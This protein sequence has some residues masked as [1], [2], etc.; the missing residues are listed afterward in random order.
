[1]GAGSGYTFF[2]NEG[3]PVGGATQLPDRA[4]Q[5]GAP[6]HWMSNVQV[7]DVDAT[8][9]EAKKLNGRVL[10]EPSEYSGVGRYALIADPFGAVI[11]VLVPTQPMKVRDVSR[12]G[13]VCWHE[14]LSEDHEASLAFYGKLFGWKKRSEFDMG[15]MGKYVLYGDDARDLGGMFTKPKEMH[16]SAWNYYFQVSDLDAAVERAKEKG[17][18]L[19]NGPMSIPSGARIAQL[20][21]P[22]GAG[23]S[24]HENPRA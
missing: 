21:D 4:K 18:K 15:A 20:S 23:F 9:A 11:R 14:L 17:G 8:V 12:P 7:S 16:A 24:L 10:V 2:L 19:C 5:M 3:S 22:Q 13:E 1:M 6:P